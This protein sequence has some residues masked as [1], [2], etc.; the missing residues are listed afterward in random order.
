MAKSKYPV[1]P[2]IIIDTREK[3]DNALFQESDEGD[4][5]VAAYRREKV[6]AG[7]YTVA[8]FDNLVVIEKKQDGK[9]L[10]GNLILNRETFL[11]SI[12][13]MR[14]FR[15]KYI[16][17][18]QSYREFLDQKNWRHIGRIPRRFQAMAT[19]ESWLINFSQTENIHF[20]FVDAKNA[21]RMAKRI[22]LKSYEYERKRRMKAEK[23][24]RT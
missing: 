4:K 1:K 20:I 22:L 18:Q 8:D 19:I 9:E 6:D 23:N 12:D 7:D 24:D 11:R 10:Y 14:K 5:D 21:P 13:R 17:I 2:T 16:L 3:P 15:H